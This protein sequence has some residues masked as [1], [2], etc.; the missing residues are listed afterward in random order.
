M[1]LRL[2]KLFYYI[3]GIFI[4]INFAECLLYINIIIP[5]NYFI[6]YNRQSIKY[7]FIYAALINLLYDKNISLKVSLLVLQNNYIGFFLYI[8]LKYKYKK[9]TAY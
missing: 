7:Y 3:L 8:I 2:K 1:F 4:L 9:F 6:K 5:T